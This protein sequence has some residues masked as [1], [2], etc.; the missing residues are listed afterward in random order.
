MEVRAEQF[1]TVGVEVRRGTGVEGGAGVRAGITVV[2]E[3]VI[4]PRP[5]PYPQSSTA[6]LSPSFPVGKIF[7]D[8][9]RRRDKFGRGVTSDWIFFFF[10]P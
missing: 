6:L 2:K 8:V 9:V 5:G 3:T 10:F 1:S 4:C 7:L